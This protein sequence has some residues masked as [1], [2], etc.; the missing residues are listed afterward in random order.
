MSLLLRPTVFARIVTQAH[1]FDPVWTA[2]FGSLVLSAIA[3]YGSEFPNLDGILYL[4]TAERFMAN[5]LAGTRELFDWNF[6]PICI[7]YVAK[8][9]GLGYEAAAYAL[10]AV[11]LAGVCA[12]LVRITEE[13][14]GGAVWCACVVA[15]A[16]PAFNGYRDFLIR[17]FGFWL[18]SVLSLLAALK[19]TTR[20]S[21]RGGLVVQVFLVIACLFR[22]E[23]LVFFAALTFWQ[24][25]TASPWRQRLQRLPMLLGLPLA[26]GLVLAALMA[27]GSL[28]MSARLV[29]FASAANP[30]AWSNFNLAAG[31]LGA[32]VLNGYSGNEASSILFFGLFSTIPK[33][34]LVRSGLFLVPL[35]YFFC[36]ASLRSQIGKWQPMTWFFAVYIVVLTVFVTNNLFMSARYVSFLNI[37]SVPLV[38]V[39]LQGLFD[40]LPRWRYV[41]VGLALLTALA[42]VISTSPRNPQYRAAGLWLSENTQLVSKI[43][44][45]RERAAYLAGPAFRSVRNWGLSDAQ[46]EQAVRNRQFEYYVLDLRRRDTKKADWARSLNLVEVERFANRVGDEVVILRLKKDT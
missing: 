2:F 45:G 34:F 8:F 23:A 15:L 27:S 44:I 14:F 6:F 7:A 24:L 3:F 16:L 25:A 35:V 40:R 12:T 1:K 41:L 19:W 17:E 13:Q 32:T 29:A 31:Q 46:I 9:T 30:A 43:Y 36:Q 42:N 5:G 11:L 4:E 21:W 37:L 38:A 22:I 20:P 18:F 28:H 26:G 39:G 33:Q 10:T